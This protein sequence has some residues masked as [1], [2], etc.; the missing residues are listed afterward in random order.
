MDPSRGS[1]ALGAHPPLHGRDKGIALDADHL[2]ILDFDSD[3]AP[4]GAHEAQGVYRFFHNLPPNCN[5]VAFS[6]KS[7]SD[8]KKTP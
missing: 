6:F 7:D 2:V 5:G 4:H 3:R 1:H 8:K